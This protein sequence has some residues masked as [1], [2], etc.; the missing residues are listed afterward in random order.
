LLIKKIH[1]IASFLPNS[2]WFAEDP[3][4]HIARIVPPVSSVSLQLDNIGYTGMVDCIVQQPDP[5]K[6]LTAFPFVD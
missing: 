1:R 5:M 3:R 2:E 6:G 4:E